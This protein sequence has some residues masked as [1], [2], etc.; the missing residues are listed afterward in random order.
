[1]LPVILDIQPKALGGI[2]NKN[3]RRFLSGV[4]F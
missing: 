1:M 4:L 2:N 3:R